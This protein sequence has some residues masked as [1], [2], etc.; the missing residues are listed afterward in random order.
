RAVDIDAVV[1]R[2][3]VPSCTRQQYVHANA[4][5]IGTRLIV[6]RTRWNAEWQTRV[7]CRRGSL[8]RHMDWRADDPWFLREHGVHE[9]ALVTY[10]Q[11]WGRLG[12]HR[13]SVQL[14][15]LRTEL[16]RGHHRDGR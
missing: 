16:A 10:H 6:G 15:S 9:L 4:R 3:L 11:P 8:G 7:E 13:V 5:R 14:A 1:R 2:R 12:Q